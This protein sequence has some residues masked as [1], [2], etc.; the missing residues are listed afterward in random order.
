M[1]DFWS[2][3]LSPSWWKLQTILSQGPWATRY[4]LQFEMP[5][6][7]GRRYVKSLVGEWENWRMAS[8]FFCASNSTT[9]I[10]RCSQDRIAVHRSLQ[11]HVLCLNL[12][13]TA[14]G[15]HL[16]ISKYWNM[17]L[18]HKPAILT[19]L[20]ML[21]NTI[22]WTFAASVYHISIS[23]QYKPNK[24]TNTMSAFDMI[25]TD[26][27]CHQCVC[28]CVQVEAKRSTF[29]YMEWLIGILTTY[30]NGLL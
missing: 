13:G 3:S 15:T 11:I 26:D 28:V 9:G 8:L 12:Y 20:H 27:T 29:H 18:Q 4:L 14:A 16:F 5:K 7:D 10:C 22:S 2:L 23:Y 6:V 21:Q 24:H 25:S 1:G 30:M 19:K 17:N